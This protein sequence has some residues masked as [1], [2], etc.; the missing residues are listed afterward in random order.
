MSVSSFYGWAMDTRKRR[1]TE[2]SWVISATT[3]LDRSMAMIKTRDTIHDQEVSFHTCQS[4][5]YLRSSKGRQEEKEIKNGRI[6][7]REEH[8]ITCP[9]VRK[10]INWICNLAPPIVFNTPSDTICYSC[11]SSSFTTPRLVW[12]ASKEIPVIMSTFSLQLEWHDS[13]TGVFYLNWFVTRD[14]Q[15]EFIYF[16]F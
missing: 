3:C 10:L 7:W 11:P 9:L 1:E 5:E 12:I 13:R 8:L 15:V 2:L 14:V 6:L 16:W 4:R